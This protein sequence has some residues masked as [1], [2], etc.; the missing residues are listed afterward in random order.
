MVSH[1]GSGI[2]LRLYDNRNHLNYQVM[3]PRKYEDRLQGFQGNLDGNVNNEFH[4]RDNTAV[5]NLYSDRVIYP[6]L[7]GECKNC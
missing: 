2:E 1:F 3:V 4:L 7:Q 6:H 5:P